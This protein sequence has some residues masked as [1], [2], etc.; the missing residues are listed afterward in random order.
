MNWFLSE[1]NIR[2]WRLIRNYDPQTAP[3]VTLIYGPKGTGKSTLV[4]ALYQR[5]GRTPGVIL[6]DGLAFSR[7]YA[8]AAQEGKLQT[9]RQRYRRAR[10]IVMD[11]IQGLS[12]KQ[13]TIEELH[14]TFDYL[15]E[16]KGK[17]V[18]TLEDAAL[19]VA[20][21]G[22]HLASRFLSGVAI[23]LDHPSVIEIERFLEEHIQSLRLVM[24]NTV[25][26][27]IAERTDNLADAKSALSG[28]IQFAENTQDALSF[29]CFK[30]Y[31]EQVMFQRQRSADPL[32][33]LRVTASTMNI[34]VEDLQG[35]S[36]KPKINEAR[37]LAI[38]LI[39]TLCYTSYP[40]LGRYFNR[41]HTTMLAA[42]QQM[43]DK[44]KQDSIIREKYE[45]ILKAFDD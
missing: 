19:D 1:F 20:F 43:H 28:F 8:Y 34:P 6:T 33:I 31:W 30:T 18:L 45:K 29:S 39:R 4:R 27:L 12:G 26:R 38:Y 24:D 9:F 5:L 37:Q 25:L 13:K 44:L 2:A 17:C 41:Q 3:G 35:P 42:Y 7:E 21:L 16:N 23:S 14:V 22:E 15:M 10:L 36:R 32:N 11:D 40:E